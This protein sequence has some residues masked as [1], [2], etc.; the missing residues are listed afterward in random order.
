MLRFVAKLACFPDDVDLEQDWHRL[1]SL[2]GALIDFLSQ[3]EA[4]Y[5]LDHREKSHR[6]AN[7]IRLQMANHV[8]RKPTRAQ[9]NLALCFLHLV[10]AE[11]RK[12]QAGRLTHHLRGLCFSYCQKSDR[13]RIASRTRASRG[14]PLLHILYIGGQVH[15]LVFYRVRPPPVCVEQSTNRH[16]IKAWS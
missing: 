7:L 1:G 13:G 3:I 2:L 8:P 6:L 9:R 5:T 15:C 14:H 11:Q 16:V 12:P 4:I 10:F